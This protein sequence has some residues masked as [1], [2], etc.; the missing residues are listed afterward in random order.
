MGS[1]SSESLSHYFQPSMFLID[2]LMPHPLTMWAVQM[3]HWVLDIKSHTHWI[4]CVWANEYWIKGKLPLM[5]KIVLQ[6]GLCAAGCPHWEGRRPLGQHEGNKSSL[7]VP[8]YWH[9]FI[10]PLNLSSCVFKRF[11]RS[12]HF[13]QNEGWFWYTTQRWMTSLWILDFHYKTIT[14]LFV[15]PYRYIRSD[16][17]VFQ[18]L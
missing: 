4:Y 8:L 10:Q 7:I 18:S 2:I 9:H 15:S 13:V 1:I 14:H 11:M 17:A 6:F 12:N 5:L 3:M 16:T